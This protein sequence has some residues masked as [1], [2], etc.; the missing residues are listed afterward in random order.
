MSS[1]AKRTNY[2]TPAAHA[3]FGTGLISITGEKLPQRLT[4]CRYASYT[5]KRAETNRMHFAGRNTS[6]PRMES[7]TLKC[8]AGITSQAKEGFE[9]THLQEKI[10]FYNVARGSTAEVRSLLYVIE[11]HFPQSASEAIALRGEIVGMGKLV[12]GL[13]RSTEDR[14]LNL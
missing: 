7:G 5:T 6:R 8:G 1:E 9:R 10:Q 4:E 11:D 14:K 12:S 2:S 13:I 3:T